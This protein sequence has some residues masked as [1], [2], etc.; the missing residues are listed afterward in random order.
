MMRGR[1]AGWSWFGVTGPL[2]LAGLLPLTAEHDRHWCWSGAWS[3][4]VGDP[5]DF[6]RDD[7]GS[8]IGYRANRNIIAG[9]GHDGV[10]LSNR[11]GGGEVRAAA[12]GLVVDA[13]RRGRADGYGH[14]VVLAHR[15][16]D[17]SLAYTV[18]AHLAGGSIRVR[19]GEAVHAG[20]ALGKVG[21]S[22]RASAP[23]LHFEVRRPDGR[24]QRWEKTPVV[25]PLAFVAARLPRRRAD[26]TWARPYLV[27]AEAAGLVG[28]QL[29][30]P[31][32]RRTDWWRMLA[33]A[34]RH[35]GARLDLDRDE[36][37][38][39]L[40][41]SRV[42]TPEILGSAGVSWQEI[43]R[44]LER[45]RERGFRLPPCLVPEAERREACRRRFDIDSARLGLRDLARL[46][47]REPTLAEACLALANLASDRTETSAAR[48]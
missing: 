47:D 5:F 45:A 21:S 48:R 44:D 29:D 6:A 3:Y 15:L 25:D 4:P 46:E 7:G 9:G 41:A 19:A 14:R 22:G 30:S 36:L 38:T 32:L 23:H 13:G 16:P 24:T 42:L 8:A 39:L 20:E 31:I 11:H 2:L 1:T 33:A 10:D 17:G 35:D 43:V 26:T 40:M 18:Y 34:T 37:Q 28:T 12:H 27:W